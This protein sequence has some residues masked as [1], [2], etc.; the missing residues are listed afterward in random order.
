M[1]VALFTSLCLATTLA[2]TGCKKEKEEAKPAP[3][4][5]SLTLVSIT[6]SN[7]SLINSSTVLNA[8]VD[9]SLADS[10]QSEYGYT[11]FFQFKAGS[12]STGPSNGSSGNVLVTERAGRVDL[13][14]NISPYWSRIQHPVAG[15]VYLGRKT[16]PTTTEILARAE[17]SFTE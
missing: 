4:T 14:T 15:Y 5:T 6:P 3:R 10:E 12:N 1:R 7:G 11:V 9:Y 17:F 2:L 13:S 16:S 8:K